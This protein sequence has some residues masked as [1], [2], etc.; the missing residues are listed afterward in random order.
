MRSWP[1][2]LTYI[3]GRVRVGVRLL[4]DFGHCCPFCVGEERIAYD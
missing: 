2:L 3:G 1:W 4:S